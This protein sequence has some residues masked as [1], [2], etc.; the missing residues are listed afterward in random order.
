[1]RDDAERSERA[2]EEFAQVIASDIFDDASAGLNSR[3]SSLRAVM[4]MT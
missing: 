3:P 1:L 4:P 2:D